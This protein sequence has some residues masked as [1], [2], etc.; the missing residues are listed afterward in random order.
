VGEGMAGSDDDALLSIWNTRL[1]QHVYLIVIFS[2]QTYFAVCVQGIHGE[3][4]FMSQKRLF[5]VFFDLNF[6]T[7]RNP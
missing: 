2:V 5:I 6:S 7:N 4:I 3:I 1:I